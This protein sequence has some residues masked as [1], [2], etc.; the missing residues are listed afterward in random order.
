MLLINTVTCE[1]YFWEVWSLYTVLSNNVVRHSK[2]EGE[3]F[4]LHCL[5][6]LVMCLF[7]RHPGIQFH[8]PVLQLVPILSILFL[9]LV[10]QRTFNYMKLEKNSYRYRIFKGIYPNKSLL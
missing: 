10:S 6:P 4:V 1:Q 7:R 2:M 9:A 8:I 3:M 5:A